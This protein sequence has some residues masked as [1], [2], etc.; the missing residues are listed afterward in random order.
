MTEGLHPDHG[1]HAMRYRHLMSGILTPAAE[2]SMR[3][4]A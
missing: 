1:T 4:V 3:P 2:Q